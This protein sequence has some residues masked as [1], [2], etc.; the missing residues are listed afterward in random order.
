[1]QE[2]ERRWERSN[3]VESSIQ[4]CIARDYELAASHE[5]EYR[6]QECQDR[7]LRDSNVVRM[8]VL[9]YAS[10]WKMILQANVLLLVRYR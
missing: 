4:P 1:M 3:S 5:T 2:E 7:C 6:I 10:D 9:I 8:I